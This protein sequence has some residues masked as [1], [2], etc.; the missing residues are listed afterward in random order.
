MQKY[1]KDDLSEIRYFEDDVIVKKWID[2]KE[3]RLMTETE[4]IK[5]ETPRLSQFHTVWNG[6]KWIDSRT[7]EEI[8]AYNRSLLPRL[9]KRQFALYLY[10]HGMY[11]QVMGAINANPRFKI[12]YDSVS[13]I[14][15]LS[16][17]VSDITT[18][19]GWTDEQVDQMWEQASTL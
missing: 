8:A 2:L 17:M 1:I 15:R 14:E 6:S 18:L 5:H 9:S 16:P 7:L 13:D 4:I 10:D 12:E 3:Y 11:D 19:L